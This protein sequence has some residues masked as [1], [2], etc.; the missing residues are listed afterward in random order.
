MSARVCVCVLGGGD[1][2]DN[3]TSHCNTI[4]AFC[5]HDLVPCNSQPIFF[6]PTSWLTYVTPPTSASITRSIT[7]TLHGSL[8]G[9]PKDFPL[10][11]TAPV[12][13]NGH[14]DEAVPSVDQ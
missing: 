2:W 4:T 14:I 1:Y 13:N 9:S 12:C 5:P 10:P 3:C 6:D 8:Q 11:V 7:L